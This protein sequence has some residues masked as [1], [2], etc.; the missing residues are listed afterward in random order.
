MVSN[1]KIIVS[2]Q[3]QNYQKITMFRLDVVLLEIVIV[4]SN[5][6]YT[7]TEYSWKDLNCYG[8]IWLYKGKQ[9]VSDYTGNIEKLRF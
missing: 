1:K 9:K 2:Y 3:C 8:R 7:P 4:G 5:L 6:V